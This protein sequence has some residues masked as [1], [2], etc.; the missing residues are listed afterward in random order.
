M[1]LDIKSEISKIKPTSAFIII[2]GDIAYEGKDK[3]SYTDFIKYINSELTE[4]GFPVQC[5][6]C[7]PGNHDVDTTAIVNN[8]ITYDG[9]LSLNLNEQQFNDFAERPNS[10]FEDKFKNYCE[11]ETEFATFTTCNKSILGQGWDLGNDISIYCLNSAYFSSGGTKDHNG[12]IL[13]DEGK[14]NISTR[15]LINWVHSCKSR[16]KILIMHH[17]VSSLSDWSQRE[18]NTIL[19]KDFNLFLHGHAHNAEHHFEIHTNGSLVSCQAPALFTDKSGELGYAIV[20]VSPVKGVTEIRYRQWAKRHHSFNS[21]SL[22]SGTDDGVIPIGEVVT[23]SDKSI[24]LSIQSIDPIDRIL[25]DRLEKALITFSSQPA[26]WIEPR[27]FEK[28]ESQTDREPDS[29][30]DI[31]LLITKPE[32]TFIFAPPQFGLTSLANHLIREAWRS[33]NQD[34]WLYLDLNE[35]LQHSRDI[36]RKINS[37]L[38]LFGLSIDKINCFV[39][40]S[41]D[42]NDKSHLKVSEYLFS[43]FTNI[44]QIIMQSIDNKNIFKQDD[45]NPWYSKFKGLYLWSLNRSS[46]RGLINQYNGVRHIA[47]EDLLT[48]RIVSDL[49]ALNIHRTP[50]NCITLLKAS[51]F[52]FEESPVNRTEVLKRVLSLLFNSNEIPTY[53]SKPDLKDCEFVLGYF[54][55]HII[56]NNAYQFSREHFIDLTNVFCSTKLIDLEVQV[57]FDVLY[58]NNIIIKRNDYFCFKFRYWIFYFAAQRMHQDRAFADYILNDK[59]YALFPEIMEFYTGIDRQR[60]NALKLLIRDLKSSINTVND[61]SGFPSDFNPYNFA[62]WK[63][64]ESSAARMNDEIVNG[65]RE[66]NLPAKIKDQIADKY[67]DKKKPYNQD[68][69]EIL[70][71]H[72]FVMMAQCMTAA[73]KALRNSDYVDP[74]IKKEL[75]DEI[76]KCWIQV[77]NILLILIPILSEHG[78]ASFGGAGFVLSD[79]FGD[80]FEKRVQTLMLEIPQNIINWYQD[81]L[82]SQKMGPLLGQ[83]LKIESNDLAKHFLVMLHIYNRPRGWRSV[84]EN[85]ISDIHKNSF[86]LY[87]TYKTLRGQYRYSYASPRSIESLGYLI[88]KAAAKHNTGIDNPGIKI[89]NKVPDSIM[90][91]REILD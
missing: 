36:D 47:D 52:E 37:E 87:N 41:F 71:E 63:P 6:I 66:S 54:C 43:K 89:I 28:Q 85:Y 39:I 40:D 4:I 9:I 80:T 3:K 20:S 86:Y 16:W 27:L 13:A 49:D 50:L 35:P 62:K 45:S 70:S 18:L 69:R 51:E 2:T 42:I 33:S 12:K 22:F 56:V 14:L 67:Y 25:T 77:S 1:L 8:L 55:E 83:Q 46:L 61:K 26:V 64:S 53:K 78:H 19:H 84:V 88:K 48:T 76:L 75:L 24:A 58:D 23:K 65:I 29:A 68:V 72:S 91:T 17:P 38:K 44:P 10:I 11:F 34:F 5:R 57:L 74:V 81:D 79:D 73:S 7:V 82:F 21:G 15:Q 32:S 90:P 59:Q 30:I 60:E 31:N